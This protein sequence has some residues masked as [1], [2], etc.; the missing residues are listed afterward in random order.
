M[1]LMDIRKDVLMVS[2]VKEGR[3]D[4][5]EKRENGMRYCDDDTEDLCMGTLFIPMLCELAR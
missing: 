2:R 1:L 3:A 5:M 4:D